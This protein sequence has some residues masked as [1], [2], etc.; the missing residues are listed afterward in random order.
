MGMDLLD[1]IFRIEKRFE[2]AIPEEVAA[3]FQ[4]VADVYAHLLIQRAALP[5]S[6]D[7]SVQRQRLFEALERS[8]VSAGIVADEVQLE[9]DLA[10]LVPARIRRQTWNH[11]LKDI[12]RGLPRLQWPRGLPWSL[13]LLVAAGCVVLIPIVYE[14]EGFLLALALPFLSMF[15]W[16]ALL[17]LSLPLAT[18]LPIDC[19]TVSDMVDRLAEAEQRQVRALSTDAAGLWVALVEV[20]AEASGEKREDIQPAMHLFKDLG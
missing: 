9:A 7:A 19:R 4:T 1:M 16:L 17:G 3:S 8:L 11:L 2:L 6:E 18:R 20:V 12:T 5:Q 13:G 15:A 14:S 10:H